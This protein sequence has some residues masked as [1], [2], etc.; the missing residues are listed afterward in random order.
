MYRPFHINFRELIQIYKEDST[1]HARNKYCSVMLTHSYPKPLNGWR[2]RKR[3][4]G[5]DRVEGWICVFSEK[6]DH[7]SMPIAQ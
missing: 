2:G 1:K 3:G 6:E 5:V 7:A 4:K